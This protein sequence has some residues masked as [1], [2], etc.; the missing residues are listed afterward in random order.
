MAVLRG[1]IKRISNIPEA[2]P[3][4]YDPL[5]EQA[6]LAGVLTGMSENHG[7]L[8]GLL[9]GRAGNPEQVW[10]AELLGDCNPAD[11]QVV[12]FARE[13]SSIFATTQAA[14]TGPELRLGL[15]L[16]DDDQSLGI[17][18]LALRDWC[19]GFLYGL[20][21]AGQPGEG[22]NGD[23]MEA[24]G[25]LAAIAAMIP[26]GEEE[27]ESNEEALMELS[28]FVWVAAMLIFEE[29]RGP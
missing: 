12:V 26:A 4:Q 24:V 8:C 11:P 10:L 19:Q 18:A 3:L 6:R 5:N 9:C 2:V 16:P 14:M 22:L 20:G 1:T 23:A 28:E 21:L 7:I 25:D 13:L 29:G 17:R 15:I 27:S